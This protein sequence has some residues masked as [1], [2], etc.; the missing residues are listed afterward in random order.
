M[1]TNFTQSELCFLIKTSNNLN[2]STQ[3]YEYTKELLELKKKSNNSNNISANLSKEEQILFENSINCYFNTFK[4]SWK[5][6]IDYL[7][8]INIS[9]TSLDNSNSNIQ[10]NNN[11]SSN[12]S[13][14]T[15][16]N[17]YYKYVTKEGIEKEIKNTEGIISEKC[18]EIVDML[19]LLSINEE[20]SSS[21]ENNTNTTTRGV[22]FYDKMKADYYKNYSEVLNEG[23]EFTTFIDEAKKSYQ[24]CYEASSRLSPVDSLTLSIA[25]NYSIF[26][27][28]ILD[29]TN[30]AYIIAN[31]ALEEA[32]SSKDT[33]DNKEMGNNDN[34]NINNSSS[35]IIEPESLDIIKK[36]EQNILIWKTELF[37]AV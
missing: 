16:I 33:K 7:N 31:K 10:H 14:N 24:K 29:N 3:S 36:L 20:N 34:N 22:M 18:M 13:N 12:N 27:S 19:D 2:L 6:L 28:S 30:R 32:K 25:L 9:S 15:T 37:D 1:K 4:E 8:T 11:K 26:E 17:S 35:N 21:E 23:T 5:N